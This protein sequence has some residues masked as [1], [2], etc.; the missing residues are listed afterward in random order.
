M[1][2]SPDMWDIQKLWN[3]AP[4]T[5]C[6]FREQSLNY[7]IICETLVS[8]VEHV[9]LCRNLKTTLEVTAHLKLPNSVGYACESRQND[10]AHQAG[11]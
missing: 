3:S 11:C 1:K 4:S 8:F 7:C 10:L 6:S 2:F 9:E 5:E